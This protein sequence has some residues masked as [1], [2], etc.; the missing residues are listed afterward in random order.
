MRSA[1]SSACLLVTLVACAAPAPDA[2]VL[3]GV[4]VSGPTCPVETTAPDP[5]CG[6][7]PVVGAEILMRDG[8]GDVVA[9]VRSGEDGRFA[10]SVPPGRY[11]V[12]PQAVPG[13]MGGAAPLVVEL[14]DG[15]T[16]AEILV[17]YDTGIR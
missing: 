7:R 1:L 17:A 13:M 5:A 14:R 2:V 10:I 9:R 15:V 11:E 3:R 8:Q 6:P 4:A 12:V 16:P